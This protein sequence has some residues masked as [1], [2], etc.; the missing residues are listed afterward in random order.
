[1]AINFQQPFIQTLDISEENLPVKSIDVLRLDAIHPI[2]SGNKWYKLKGHLDNIITHR[3]KGFVTFGGAF[4][5]HLSAAA[6]AAK[7]YGL[8][9]VAIIRG[10]ELKGQLSPTLATCAAN[11]MQLKFVSRTI[12]KQKY[13]KDY[14]QLLQAEFPDYLIIPEG[15]NSSMGLLGFDEIRDFIHAAYTHIILAVGTGTSF[16]AIHNLLSPNQ[17]LVGFVPMKQ[18]RYLFHEMDLNKAN[19]TLIDDYHFGGFGK[20]NQEL[21]DFM[22]KFYARYTLPLDVVYTSK[23]MYGLMAEI[24][25]NR[26]NNSAR[27]LVI[28]TGGLQG[29]ASVKAQLDY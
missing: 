20:Y 26:I 23:M 21:L 24:Q 12:Y 11:G 2:V 1:M 4:S 18:G 9:A 17:Q 14:L 22:N 19:I 25:N 15:G 27:I 29:N 8:E 10:E 6:F 16:K 5:N 28:H 13:N 3:L 7:M